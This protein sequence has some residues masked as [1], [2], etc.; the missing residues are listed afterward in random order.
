[1]LTT[2]VV[3]YFRQGEEFGLGHGNL[4]VDMSKVND[5]RKQMIEGL[6]EAH[7]ANFERNH[8]EIIR[9]FGRFVGENSVQVTLNGGGTRTLQSSQ[10]FID[11]RTI[12]AIYGMPCE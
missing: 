7:I 5:R 11:T 4:G 12:A 10:I 3:L 1:M 2:S 6:R 9:G 8:A